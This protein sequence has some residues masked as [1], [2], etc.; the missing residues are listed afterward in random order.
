MLK[1]LQNKTI[2]TRVVLGVVVGMLGVGMLVYLV[3]QGSSNIASSDNV[4][5]VGGQPVTVV[6]VRRQLDRL[7]RGG[8]VPK[9]LEPLYAQQIVNQLIFERMLEVEA[10]RQGIRVSQ[11]EQIARIRQLVPSSFMGDSVVGMEQ[12]AAEVSGRFGMAVPEFEELIRQA[13]LEDKVRHVVTDGITVTPEEIQQEFRRRNEK[14]K[15]DYVLIAPDALEAKIT[16]SDAELASYFEKNKSRYTVPE[17]RVVRYAMLDVNLL[18][19]RTQVPEADIRTY[20]NEHLDQYKVEN[21]AHVE[22]IL[23]KTIGK[24]DAEVEEIRKK[25]EDVL[26]QA[27]HGAKFEDL[28]KKYSEDTTK[29][30]GGDIGWIKQGQ[31]LPEYEKTAFSAS[32]DS[33]SDLIRT[34]IGFYI[35]KVLDREVARTKNLDEVRSQIQPILAGQKADQTA[36]ETS[37]KIADAI[38]K[39]SRI[40]LEQLAK[41]FNL[42]LTETAPVSNTDPIPELGTSQE[43]R[44]TIFR[45]RPG[46][47]NLPMR[48]DRGYV[49]LTVKEIQPAHPG[50]LAEVKDKVL[51][52]YRRE[53]SVELAKTRAEEL[54]KRAQAGENLASAAKALGLDSK[55]S[56]PFARNGSVTG[57]G[58]A[59]QLSALFSAKP[60]QVLPP[61][62]MVPNWV[63]CKLVE[64][65]EAKPEDF[66]KQKADI[67]QQ[68]LQSK[69]ELAYEAF[70]NA[71]EDRLKAEGLLK[72]N[73]DSLKRL[74]NPA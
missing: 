56:E 53:R 39:T 43:I 60:G 12:Y 14:V 2:M 62:N 66:D 16:P 59:R 25:A 70:R 44:E 24:T 10:K 6:E 36:G 28:A 51:T 57:L 1:A 27:K 63:V 54:A 67:E 46:D 72:F 18:R 7:A 5:D 13:I 32:K 31:A 38:R 26:K 49:V 64:R 71:L 17:R 68:L 8:Q 65:T 73:A 4:A 37:D 35:I 50:A 69:R 58:S 20:Y 74:T 3:P 9:A 61:I 33:V 11:E 40:P 29:D 23:F 41:Q 30:K 52:D 15:M 42:T 34:Q 22:H 45:L 47:V 48:L 19:Q 21:R 55:T